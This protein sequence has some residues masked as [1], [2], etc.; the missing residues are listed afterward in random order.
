MEQGFG[1][2]QVALRVFHIIG[3]LRGFENLQGCFISRHGL[4]Q[5]CG[6]ALPFAK[7]QKGT[8]QVVLGYGPI[9]LGSAFGIG[10]R[11]K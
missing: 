4:F 8:S 2:P 10:Q 7:A 6:A 3:G 9:Q 1:A 11:L 5:A